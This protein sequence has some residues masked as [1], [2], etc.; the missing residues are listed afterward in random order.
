MG[1]NIEQLSKLK[2]NATKVKYKDFTF[3]MRKSKINELATK[4]NKEP[5]D[6]DL[7][8]IAEEYL[9]QHPKAPYILRG[10]L[11]RGLRQTGQKTINNITEGVRPLIWSTN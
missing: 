5:H 11:K 6:H 8:K 7:R 9:K 10:P 4:I 1:K 2:F 3:N